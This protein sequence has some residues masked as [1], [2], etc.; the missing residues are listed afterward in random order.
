MKTFVNAHEHGFSVDSDY[1]RSSELLQGENKMIQNEQHEITKSPNIRLS[2]LLE[3]SGAQNNMGI[4]PVSIPISPNSIINEE[5]RIAAGI[6][7]MGGEDSESA[8]QL[9]HTASS[10]GGA[11]ST[12]MAPKPQANKIAKLLVKTRTGGASRERQSHS[13]Q[14]S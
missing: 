13:N 4:E 6:T 12:K 1:V 14:S 5:Q 2:M 10:K 7:D 8:N 11:S 3:K 9:H